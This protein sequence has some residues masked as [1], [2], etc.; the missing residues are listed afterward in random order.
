MEEWQEP[1]SVG[2]NMIRVCENGK[3]SWDIQTDI[4]GG[5]AFWN[6]VPMAR[7][8]KGQFLSGTQ[9][10][11]Q[12]PEPFI[13]KDSPVECGLNGCPLSRTSLC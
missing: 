10:S 2:E 11:Q 6:R 13:K 3:Y 5:I 12:E 7:S 9:Q 4:V 1:G 8:G